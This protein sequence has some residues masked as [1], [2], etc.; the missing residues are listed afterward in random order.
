MPI[1]EFSAQQ[2]AAAIAGHQGCPG[3]ELRLLLLFQSDTGDPVEAER[4]F[5]PDALR[6]AA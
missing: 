1:K 2:I 5:V 3:P 4:P 6:N